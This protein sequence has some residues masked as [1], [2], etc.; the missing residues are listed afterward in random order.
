M[1]VIARRGIAAGQDRTE[2]VMAE[3]VG[4][5]RA[6]IGPGSSGR[7]SPRA[8]SA[9]GVRRRSFRHAAGSA[10]SAA[11]P[12][13]VQDGLRPALRPPGLPMSRAPGCRNPGQRPD[14]SVAIPCHPEMPPAFSLNVG[15][16]RQASR[17][18][19]RAQRNAP[20]IL[21]AGCWLPS[22]TPEIGAWMPARRQ[23][24]KLI[25]RHL[26]QRSDRGPVAPER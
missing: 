10:A 6:D 8:S 2:F 18:R 5:D 3:I 16:A 17:L 14:Q 24:S 25:K 23:L 26:C 4:S 1:D 15:P 13:R 9:P 22:A 11:T 12:A 20:A 7:S 21:L 19:R